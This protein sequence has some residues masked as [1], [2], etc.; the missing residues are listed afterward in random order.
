M[1]V[2]AFILLIIFEMPVSGQVK[3]RLLADAKPELVILTV[4]EGKYV[5]DY[6]SGDTVHISREEPVILALFNGRLAV[7]E[8]NKPGYSVD[9]I[10]FT[11]IATDNSFSLKIPGAT[12]ARQYYSGDLECLS[13]LGTIVMIN[14]CDEEKYIAGVVRAEGGTGRHIEY[15]KSQAVIARTYMYR[16]LGKHLNDGYNLCDN[17]HC[18][19]YNGLCTDQAINRATVDTKGQ[20]ILDKDNILIISAFHSNCGGETSSAEDVWLTDVPYLKSVKDPWCSGTR[21]SS[22]QKSYSADSWINMIKR[23]GHSASSVALPDTRFIQDTRVADY[24]AGG[25]RVPLRDIRSDLNLR[26]TYFSVIPEGNDV[27]LKG[28]GYG[29]GVGLCQE[30]A[31]EMAA[32]GYRY[33][34][35]ISFYYSEVRISQ[36][37]S[38]L[39]VPLII[40]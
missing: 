24:R 16:Y 23:V 14:S 2:I 9:S 34:Q 40:K 29:H 31:M 27:I 7:K 32:K 15:F 22:W 37:G 13:D 39:S 17:T 10:M 3:I 36:I 30:G 12:T 18:Q 11:G 28:K 6:F 35:I 33:G 25:V 19:A 21:N 8:R 4:T 20:V 1:R 26:S 5:L 38:A